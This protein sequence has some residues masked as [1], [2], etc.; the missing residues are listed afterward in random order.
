MMGGSDRWAGKER[1]EWHSEG[2]SG[3]RQ[4]DSEILAG[5]SVVSSLVQAGTASFSSTNV[6]FSFS[7][8]TVPGGGLLNPDSLLATLPD[9]LVLLTPAA[10]GVDID[11][12][13]PEPEGLGVAVER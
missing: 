13:K 2:T 7:S 11:E 5:L 4:N 12:F 10:V 1:S 9:E 8:L 6:A 3:Q